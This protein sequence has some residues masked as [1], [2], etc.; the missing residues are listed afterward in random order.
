MFIY[1]IINYE[2]FCTFDFQSDQLLQLVVNT[3]R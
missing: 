1:L 3:Y 2:H